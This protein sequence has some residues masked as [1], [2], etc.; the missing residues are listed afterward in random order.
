MIES[1]IPG[2]KHDPTPDRYPTRAD[3]PKL[4]TYGTYKGRPVKLMDIYFEYYA[5]FKTG[6]YSVMRGNLQKFILNE[7]P[8]DATF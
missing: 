3:W 6:P 8:D 7:R 5:L 4:G 1:P 2:Y